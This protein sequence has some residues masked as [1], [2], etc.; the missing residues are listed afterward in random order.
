MMRSCMRCGKTITEK[1]VGHRIKLA[2]GENYGE[3][4]GRHILQFFSLIGRGFVKAE[5][6]GYIELCDNCFEEFSGILDSW[7]HAS[8]ANIMGGAR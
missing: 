1:G 2:K 6:E 5:I 3:W 4:I 8:G 7:L